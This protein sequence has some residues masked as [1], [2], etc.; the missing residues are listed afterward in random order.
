MN[1]L[2]TGGAGFIGSHLAEH[3]LQGGHKVV[4]YDNLSRWKLLHR[5]AGRAATAVW[6][7]LARRGDVEC[8]KADVRDLSALQP[9]VERCECIIHTAGQTAVTV[10]LD[11]PWEDFSVNAIGT[12]TLLEAARR[13]GGHRPIIFCSTNKVYGENVNAIPIIE[14]SARYRFG[15]GWQHGV[16]ESLSVDARHHTPYGASKLTAD[17]YM[18]EYAASFGMKVGV[19]RMSCIYGSRQFGVED[20]GWVAWFTIATV[21]G[22]PLSIYGDGKQVRDVLHV[23][24]LARC[25][26]TFV[27]SPL[28]VG[29]YNVGG[30]PEFSLSLLE[31]L[32]LLEELTGSRS[33]LTFAAWRPS[34]QKVYVSDI[35][36][37]QRELGWK[38]AIAPRQGVAELVEW[39]Q[40]NRSLLSEYG[41]K[42]E[43]HS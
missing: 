28:S 9:Y 27:R 22:V 41:G 14:E 12:L 31:L 43:A 8:V 17:I 19:F 7:S 11:E 26:E 33:P 37:V 38:P 30:G 2:I 4:V 32:G 34:D 29:L 39:V 15:D 3:F 16:P 1:I 35:R 13:A 24:D 36:L 20:Q 18:Q 10:S 23:Q 25:F 5:S 40:S 6:E 42:A 21:L